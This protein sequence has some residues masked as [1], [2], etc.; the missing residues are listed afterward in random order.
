M[1]ACLFSGRDQRESPSKASQKKVTFDLSGDEDS[2]GEDMEEIF[3][4]KAPSSELSEAKSSY[5]KRREK[6]PKLQ[7]LPIG[8]LTDSDV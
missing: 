3:G 1:A 2:E 6:V 4:G 7:K 8:F 5:E